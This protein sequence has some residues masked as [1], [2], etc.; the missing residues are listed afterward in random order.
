[1]NKI[2]YALSFSFYPLL[3]ILLCFSLPDDALEKSRFFGSLIN[4]LKPYMLS[5]QNFGKNAA[6][7]DQYQIAL[8]IGL[9]FIPLQ[10]F[11]LEKSQQF[12][13][14]KRKIE[15]IPYAHL[16]I[17]VCLFSLFLGFLLLR[18]GANVDGVGSAARTTR[19]IMSNRIYFSLFSSMIFILIAY[20][21][22]M[23]LMHIKLLIKNNFNYPKKR[24]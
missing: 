12:E 15:E 9:A 10:S 8:L 23:L 7:P 17:S 3:F 21:F 6:F 18:Y 13:G 19:R 1:M 24:K 14:V 22:T 16:L 4:C 20:S 11:F 5:L 2:W